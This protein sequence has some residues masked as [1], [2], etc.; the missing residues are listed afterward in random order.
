[1]YTDTL[2]SSLAGTEGVDVGRVISLYQRYYTRS[3]LLPF[4]GYRKRHPLLRMLCGIYACPP[5]IPNWWYYELIP[6]LPDEKLRSILTRITPEDFYQGKLNPSLEGEMKS[7]RQ[8]LR[9][10]PAWTRSPRIGCMLIA[11]LVGGT[12][13]VLYAR[14][15][16][17]GMKK[18]PNQQVVVSAHPWD[19]LTMGCSRHYQSCQALDGSGHKATEYN[20]QLPANLLDSGMLVAYIPESCEASRWDLRRM[21]TRVILRLLRDRAGTWGILIDRFYGDLGQSLALEASLIDILSRASLQRWMP[22]RYYRD[23]CALT[24]DGETI[25]VWGPLQSFGSHWCPYLDQGRVNE[26]FCWV[27]QPRHGRVYQRLAAYALPC[28][29][30][31]FAPNSAPSSKAHPDASSQAASGLR[32]QTASDTP[33][34]HACCNLAAG[35]HLL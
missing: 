19:I 18:G 2:Q 34:Q 11:S 27:N 33:V 1:M 30:G 4:P 9:P 24:F 14:Y 32:R 28:P 31:A 6:Q 10:S 23:S 29:V 12:S 7:Y 25:G 20:D 13:H 21:Q 5:Q 17:R 35:V 16:D 8:T 26:D 22:L 15:L 3:H